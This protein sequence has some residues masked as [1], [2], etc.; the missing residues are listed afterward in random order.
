MIKR[1]F[2]HFNLFIYNRSE[3]GD[4]KTSHNSKHVPN[5]QVGI[6]TSALQLILQS[7]SK[8]E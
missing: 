2:Q 1:K 4:P 3:F 6:K 7:F 8:W 5:D